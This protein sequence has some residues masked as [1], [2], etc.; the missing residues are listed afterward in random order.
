MST[1]AAGS[2]TRVLTATG[3]T[4]RR[5]WLVLDAL[6]SGVSGVVLLAGAPALDGVLGP[7]TGVLLGLGAFF[8]LYAASLVVLARIGSPRT[9][10][11]VVAVG[12]LGWVGLSLGVVLSDALGLTTAGTVVAVLQ[13]VAIAV[14]A[15]LQLLAARR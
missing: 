11:R 2:H 14:V 12:N 8:V 9:A 5:R 4:A 10:V 6:L 7:S 1:V 15:D 3:P 13:A